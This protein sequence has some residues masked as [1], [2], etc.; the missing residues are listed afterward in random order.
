MA[1]REE[2]KYEKRKRE[3][4]SIETMGEEEKQRE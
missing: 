1:E 2:W 4:R 3:R